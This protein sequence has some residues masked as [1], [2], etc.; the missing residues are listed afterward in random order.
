MS[1][2]IQVRLTLQHLS[3]VVATGVTGARLRR[4]QLRGDKPH[5]EFLENARRRPSQTTN[6]KTGKTSIF[7]PPAPR[8]APAKLFRNSRAPA[9]S[10]PQK[11]T[12]CQQNALRPPRKQKIQ[13]AATA[14]RTA[15]EKSPAD[16]KTRPRKLMAVFF[17]AAPRLTRISEARISKKR[18]RAPALGGEQSMKNTCG[19]DRP[20]K[21]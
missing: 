12:A 11:K 20:V 21:K 8:R 7:W 17:F 3:D 1:A 10:T 5:R 6:P 4:A 16:K 14:R 15:P 9:K 18:K 2:L 13:P 19:V